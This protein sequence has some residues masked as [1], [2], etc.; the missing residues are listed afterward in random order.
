MF[1]GAG[2]DFFRGPRDETA[3]HVSERHRS[4]DCRGGDGR[5]R[6]PQRRFAPTVAPACAQKKPRMSG[7]AN[8]LG[9]WGGKI[10]AIGRGRCYSS[11]VMIVEITSSACLRSLTWL[12]SRT[13]SAFFNSVVEMP[14]VRGR[15]TTSQTSFKSSNRPCQSAPMPNTDTP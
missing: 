1:F 13:R 6:F 9:R 3:A 11:R 12:W 5:D 8:H 4:D 2:E 7:A 10:D 15:Y 14:C